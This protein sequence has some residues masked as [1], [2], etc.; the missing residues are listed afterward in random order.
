MRVTAW[1]GIL[2]L[3]PS[4]AQFPQVRTQEVRMGQ[5]RPAIHRIAQDALGL[6]WIGSDKGLLRTD[7]EQVEVML[8]TDPAS[9]TALA[10]ADNG[11]VAAL[12]DGRIVRC[13]GRS[14]EATPLGASLIDTPARGILYMPDGALLLGTYGAGLWILREGRIL[15]VTEK[16]GLPDDHV[17]G[18]CLLDDGAVVAATDQG[19]ALLRDDRV[20][21]VYGEAEGAPDNLVL[22]VTTDGTRVWAGTDRHGPFRWDPRTDTHALHQPL[23]TWGHG[24]VV[25]IAVQGGQLWLGT[26]RE[27]LLLHEYSPSAGAG[28]PPLLRREPEATGHG[29]HDLFV[30]RDGAAW[31]CRGTE[32]LHRADPRVLVIADHEGVDLRRI[33]AITVD[34]QERI[35]FATQEGLFHHPAAFAEGHSMGRTAVRTDPRKPIVSL[36]AAE[37]GT[38]WAATFGDGVIAMSPD[39]R[40]RR[41]ISRESGIDDDVLVARARGDTVWF[42]TLS[43]VLEWRDGRFH[44]H[45]LPGTG[46]VYD[47]LPLPRGEVLAATD[48]DGV[49][50]YRDGAWQVVPSPHRTF[51]T[52]LRDGERRTWAAGPGTGLCEVMTDGVRC[53]GQDLVPFDGDLFALGRLGSMIAAFGSTGIAA[54]DPGANAWSDLGIMLGLGPLDAELNNACDDATGALW[55]AST[56]GL[57]R[58][59]STNQAL[60]RGIPTVITAMLIG[61]ESVGPVSH[62]TTPH[63]RNDITFHFTGLHY[64]DPGALRFEVRLLGHDDRGFITRDRA[65]AWSALPPGEYRF[66]VRA[67]IGEA[68]TVDNWAEVTWVV[69]PPWWRRPWVIVLAVLSIATLV[70]ASVRAREKRLRER[71]R[72]RRE[73]VRFQLDALRSQVDPHFLFNSFNALVELIET[74]PGKAVEHVELL[75]VFFRNI[76]QV[77]DRERITLAEEIALLRTYF[78]LE[79]RRFGDTIAMELQVDDAAR[80]KGIV[81]LTLQLLVENALKHNIIAGDRVFTIHVRATPS[82]VEVENP[83]VPRLSP[84]RSTG[85]GLESITKRYAAL[86]TRPVE[87]VR[88][89]SDFLVRIPLLG[90]RP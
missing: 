31:W 77:R 47:V 75:S 32:R 73:Q 20:T 57:V 21:Q 62:W 1:L 63:D 53:A 29:V 38:V 83:L 50:R 6:V 39:G 49:V 56:S 42:G 22:S 82:H 9:V 10:A 36:T 81:P 48:G 87:V 16:D 74:D 44:R 23:E 14:C 78:A 37:D 84:P 34:R 45:D 51:Y 40:V 52:L 59:R 64:A 25:A 5:Q 80:T 17:N 68:P 88:S 61:N 41:H 85:F 55:L 86:T 3:A 46:F 67:F 65:S 30:D 76:L 7:G 69:R 8:R 15:R 66:Q 18:L 35:W 33:T 60:T 11:V 24:A 90:P 12:S 4:F 58:I 13:D 70:T 43:G 54:F 28:A 79:Q 19:L 89:A 72:M 71:E 26:D 2:L 27:G